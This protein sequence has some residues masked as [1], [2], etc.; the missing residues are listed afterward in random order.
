M[1]ENIEIKRGQVVVFNYKD[2]KY[3]AKIKRGRRTN[4]HK[5]M[6]EEH[7]NKIKDK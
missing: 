2:G 5:R 4:E 3:V 7:E 1:K 6:L